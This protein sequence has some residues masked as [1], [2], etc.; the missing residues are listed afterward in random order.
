MSLGIP[1]FGDIRR[2]GVESVVPL[3]VEGDSFET[4]FGLLDIG[5]GSKADSTLPAFPTT[6]LISGIFATA[7]S[8]CC[9]TRL[10]SS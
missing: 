1:T 3:I 6:V 4:I 9:N 8:N 2:S 7:I 5:A 10:F